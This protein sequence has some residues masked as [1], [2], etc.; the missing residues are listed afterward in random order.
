M[1]DLILIPFIPHRQVIFRGISGTP[2]RSSSR[3][4][5]SREDFMSS[6]VDRRDFLKLAGLG[7]AVFASGLGFPGLD[8]AAAGE[9][10]FFVQMTDTHWGF[11][12]PQVNPEAGHT[13][14]KAVEAVNALPKQPDFIM[15]T[16]DLT[17]T[18]D[19]AHGRRRRLAEFRDIVGGLKVRTIRYIP[20]EHDAS[21]DAGQAFTELFGPTH[22]AFT[23]KGINFVAL[24]NV[25]DAGG[26]LGAGQLAW[27]AAHLGTLD[28]EQPLIVVTHRPLF[29]LAP[30][31]DW[32]T[33]DGALAV[34]QLMPFK[35]V[36]VFYGHIHL[37]H[38]HATGHIQH[39]AATSLIFPQPAPKSQARRT[40]VAWDPA[41][42]YRGLGFRRVESYGSTLEI[43]EHS[44]AG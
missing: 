31:W 19:D 15:F 39:H 32:A 11:K 33:R 37:E 23:P 1:I 28:R 40:A 25:S 16:G 24:D 34:E 14:H 29:D 35:N 7:S 2:P 27:L 44:L 10:F 26:A 42:P 4:S 18:V 41:A 36:A 13:L 17:H 20:G 12:N 22:Y 8:A 9:D 43:E 21:L 5:N 3:R 38:H 30:E 6:D